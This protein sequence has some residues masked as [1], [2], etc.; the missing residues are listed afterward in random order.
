[1]KDRDLKI[2]VIQKETNYR[3][4]LTAEKLEAD[5]EK[6]IKDY[7]QSECFIENP[8]TDEREKQ[9]ETDLQKAKFILSNFFEDAQL[10]DLF[11]VLRDF[12]V[13]IIFMLFIN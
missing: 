3:D 11:S 8:M 9:I 1:M 13:F 10:M 7:F 4:P 5:E 6:F 12:E 2:Q